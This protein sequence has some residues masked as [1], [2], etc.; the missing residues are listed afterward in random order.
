MAVPLDA[1]DPLEALVRAKHRYYN[2]IAAGG[3]SVYDEKVLA[4]A[5]LYGLPMLRVDVPNPT[6]STCRPMFAVRPVKI[7]RSVVWFV[8][9]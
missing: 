4:E 8:W 5:T 2:S 6:T 7:R 9:T 3:L 1:D